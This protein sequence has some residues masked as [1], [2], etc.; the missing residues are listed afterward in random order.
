MQVSG[1]FGRSPPRALEG[2]RTP[3]L[4]IRSQM[5]YPLSYEC[6][7]VVSLRPGSARSYPDSQP[8]QGLKVLLLRWKIT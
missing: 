4:L 8:P 7:R 3:N 5:L 2:T 6:L 1:H